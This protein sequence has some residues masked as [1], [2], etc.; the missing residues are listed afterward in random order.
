MT[1][2]NAP[3]EAT[4]C[5]PIV[6]GHSGMSQIRDTFHVTAFMSALNSPVASSPGSGGQRFCDQNAFHD[7]LRIVLKF[8]WEKVII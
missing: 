3:G 1:L 4:G 2:W 8:R 5:L 7:S 6:D